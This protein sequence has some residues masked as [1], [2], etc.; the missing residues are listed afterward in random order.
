M[1][2]PVREAEDRKQFVNLPVDVE[3]HYCTKEEPMPIEIAGKV[4]ELKQLWMHE[5]AEETPES[6]E[7]DGSYMTCRCPY[8]GHVYTN[9]IGD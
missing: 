3:I 9:F 4:V 1:R 7:A 8:C 6:M 2:D 5:D